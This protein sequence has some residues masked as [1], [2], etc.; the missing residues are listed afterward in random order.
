MIMKFDTSEAE[1]TLTP[2]ATGGECT[3]NGNWSGRGGRTGEVFK[4]SDGG[5]PCSAVGLG[6]ANWEGEIPLYME[7]WCS[8]AWN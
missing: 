5:R 3:R 6:T 2:M 1:G 7:I 8:S 4:T